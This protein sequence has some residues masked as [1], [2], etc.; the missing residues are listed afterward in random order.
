MKTIFAFALISL[1]VASFASENIVCALNDGTENSKEKIITA[2]LL[3]DE[4]PSIKLKVGDFQIM[5]QWVPA[6]NMVSM[7]VIE[8]KSLISASTLIKDPRAG[9]NIFAAKNG[10]TVDL[11]CRIE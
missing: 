10:Q 2:P 11:D 5:A 1:S 4:K 9:A 8:I 3:K 6:F 7:G